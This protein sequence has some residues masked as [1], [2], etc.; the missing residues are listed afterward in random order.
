MQLHHS[1]PFPRD[2][3]HPSLLAAYKVSK[4]LAQFGG[5]VEYEE[6]VGLAAFILGQPG[7]YTRACYRVGLPDFMPHTT[8]FQNRRSV[9]ELL[10]KRKN[11]QRCGPGPPKISAP[12]ER[13]YTNPQ[14]I[15]SS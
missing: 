13:R 15:G 10:V 8:Q 5:L 11:A 1:F 9:C 3:S 4:C 12:P 14:C 6:G 2:H 7:V